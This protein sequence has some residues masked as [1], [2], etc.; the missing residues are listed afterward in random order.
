MKKLWLNDTDYLILSEKNNS[1]TEEIATRGRIDFYSIVGYLPNPD[2]VLKK[3]GKD[4]TVY[5]E[6]LSDARVGGCFSSRKAG[7]TSLEWDIDRGKAK[8][9]QAKLIID[10]F[11]NLDIYTIISSALESIFYGYAI[12]EIVW[13]KV[14]GY[15]LP[16]KIIGKPQEWF[17]FDRENRLLLRNKEKFYEGDPVPEYK[18]IVVQHNA[19]YKNP[20]GL[21]IASMCFWPVT[22]K[23]G[24]LKFWLM[25][26]EKYG[27]PFLIGKHPRGTSLEDTNKLADLLENMIQDAIAVI[28]DD[29]S[30]EILEAGGKSASAGIYKELLEYCD[31]E[32]TIALLGQNLTTQVKSGSYAAAQTHMQVRKDL[33]DSD[34][35][36][37]E[38]A[39]NHIIRWIYELN[40]SDNETPVFSMY[41]QEDVDKELAERDEKLTNSLQLA[42]LK[43][44]KRYFQKYYALEDEDIEEL[45]SL[46]IPTEHA[47][48]PNPTPQT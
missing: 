9:R 5:E 11:K 12:L 18:F 8:T 41:E 3:Q 31:N 34:K 40:F 22:F 23:R 13:E 19:T 33:I 48:P 32:I 38:K 10:V 26:T 1:L 43:L 46:K 24:G 6:I 42:G 44:T 39:M 14:G 36:M 27:M 2:P 35:I 17:T 30:V 7:V 28:P 20:Y 37:I 16:K 45:S 4:I 47:E 25:F 15:I 21:P 29:S